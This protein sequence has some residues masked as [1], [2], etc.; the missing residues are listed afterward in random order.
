M[1][2]ATLA[3]LRTAL[4]D[5]KLWQYAWQKAF[6]DPGGT[7]E[8]GWMSG[9]KAAGWPVA[10]VDPATTPGTAYTSTQLSPVTGSIPLPNKSP[11]TK[12]VLRVAACPTTASLYGAVMVYDRL[13]GVSG[14]SLASTGDKA[15]NDG[16][17]SLPRYA[18]G[19]GVIPVMEVTT[20]GTTTAA[21]VTLTSY[22]NQDGD[23][24][25]GTNSFTFQTVAPGAGQWQFLPLLTGDMGC[26]SVTTLNVGTAAT[27]LVVNALLVKP[28]MVIPV[29]ANLQATEVLSV[30]QSLG[31]ARVY[32]GACLGLAAFLSTSSA[33]TFQ[34]LL[35]IAYG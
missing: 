34:G 25:T 6:A 23:T 28:L 19:A 18:D 13:Y 26:R 21:V 29:F 5:G 33:F 1:G 24:I 17:V 22:V 8:Y 9:W 2:F 27:A 14:I 4:D 20:A 32:D 7:G 15:L 31:L 35:D 12:H 3:A 30:V 10:G 16:T 11:K